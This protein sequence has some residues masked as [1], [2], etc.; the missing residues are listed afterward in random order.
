MEPDIKI[1]TSQTIYIGIGNGYKI[2]QN[3]DAVDNIGFPGKVTCFNRECLNSW[4]IRDELIYNMDP[5]TFLSFTFLCPHSF[6]FKRF[7]VSKCLI[8]NSQKFSSRCG[9]LKVSSAFKFLIKKLVWGEPNEIKKQCGLLQLL[10]VVYMSH[11]RSGLC[12]PVLV[13]D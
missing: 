12:V 3:V 5:S 1:C 13:T 4:H 7:S 2:P 10:V 8:L 6:I 11:I 9:F